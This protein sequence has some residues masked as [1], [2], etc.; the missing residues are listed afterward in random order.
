MEKF[1]KIMNDKYGTYIGPG[2]WFGFDDRYM[3]IGYAWP[4][5]EELRAGLAG[6][7]AA[8]REARK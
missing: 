2:H 4:L 7:S 1:Y 8:I 6:I 3:R 5:E